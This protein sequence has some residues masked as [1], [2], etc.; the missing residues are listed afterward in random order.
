[1]TRLVRPAPTSLG[2]AVFVLALFLAGVF[3]LFQPPPAH[4]QTVNPATVTISSQQ[5]TVYEGQVVTYT[6]TRIGGTV[7]DELTVVLDTYETGKYNSTLT[8]HSVTF[9][10]GATSADLTVLVPVDGDSEPG[11]NT[12][13]AEIRCVNTL[14]YN[15]GTQWYADIEIDDAPQDS[16]FVSVS[17]S[18]TLTSE[19]GSATLTFTRTGGSNAQDLTVDFQVDDPEDR[20]RGNHWDPAPVIPTQ[21]VIPA[22]STTAAITLTFPDDQRDLPSAGLVTVSVLPSGSYVLELQRRDQRHPQRHRQ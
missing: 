5:T 7:G 15:C 10:P 13:S 4:A 2:A 17:A 11:T 22:G 19:G 8:E 14:P 6:L 3:S 12:F 16:Q 1:M 20:L 18:A 21:V 9:R